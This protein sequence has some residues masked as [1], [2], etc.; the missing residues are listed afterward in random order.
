MKLI[1]LSEQLL[2]QMVV[3]YKKNDRELFDLDFF[4]QLHPN[5][6]ENSLSKALYLLEEEGFVSIL[7][8][9]NVAY[10]TALNPRGIANVEE[11]TLLKKGYTLIKEIKSLIQ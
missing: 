3:E 4:K 7:P 11:N 5:E 10:I 1:K 8:A 9:D 2:K 6:T